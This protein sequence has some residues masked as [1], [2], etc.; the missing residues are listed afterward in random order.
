MAASIDI[1]V[2]PMG[3]SISEAT[4]AGW[5]KKPG[6]Q[7]NTGDILVELETD[8]VTMEVPAPASG[9]LSKIVKNS[10]EIVKLGDL[11]ATLEEG[12]ATAAA[13]PATAAAAPQP[14]AQSQNTT[15]APGAARL[16][17]EA[18][19][20]PASVAGTG[21]RGQVRKEDIVNHL[22]KSTPDVPP[23]KSRP[24]STAG[25]EVVQP[26][27]PLRKKIAER[28]V[29]AQQTAAILT[30]FNEVDMQRVMDLRAKYKDAFKEKHGAALGFMSFFTRAAIEALRAFPAVNAEIRGTDIVYKNYFDIGVAVGG[31][32]GLVVPIIRNAEQLSFAELEKEILRLAVKVKES[33]ISLDDLQGGTFTISNGGVYGSMLSTPILNPPQS[34]ILGMHNIV[35][36]AVVIDDQIVIRPMMYLALSYDHRI[37]DG[38]EAVSFLVRIKECIENPERMLLD[39]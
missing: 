12:A 3:E 25:R 9:V 19:V 29:Q 8:K 39:I 37:I 4:V 14:A 24:V 2:P 16:A 1:K 11:L 23:G 10:G 36:R 7:V 22:E 18:G 13:K 34:G 38:R 5:R 30:T 31:P 27:S 21:V 17:S 32:K 28:L 26:M 20:N 33:S 15:L 6:E 35:K